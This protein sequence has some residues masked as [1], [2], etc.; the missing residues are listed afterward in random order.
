MIERLSLLTRPDLVTTPLSGLAM[1]SLLDLGMSLSST[2]GHNNQ[3]MHPKH[4]QICGYEGALLTGIWPLP[5]VSTNI[6]S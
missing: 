3:E 4:G 6:K 1:K 2:M 5:A